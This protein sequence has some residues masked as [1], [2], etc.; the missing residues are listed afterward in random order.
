MGCLGLVVERVIRTALVG[1]H[2]DAFVPI[3]AFIIGNIDQIR[4]AVIARTEAKGQEA[5]LIPP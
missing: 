1:A 5:R 4:R 2:Q 3:D